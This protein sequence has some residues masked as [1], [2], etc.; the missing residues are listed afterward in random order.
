MFA[1]EL[2]LI[3][4][5]IEGKEHIGGVAPFQSKLM[6]GGQQ[7]PQ[8]PIQPQYP[9]QQFAVPQS[10]LQ[11]GIMQ[12]GMMDSQRR[13]GFQDANSN[14]F[15][16]QAASGFQQFQ[17]Q[18]GS[19][20]VQEQTIYQNQGMP[21]P[22]QIVDHQS[23]F[24]NPRPPSQQMLTSQ[25]SAQQDPLMFNTYNPQTNPTMRTSQLGPGAGNLTIVGGTPS[26]INQAFGSRRMPIFKSG[27]PNL[28]W[29]S[30]LDG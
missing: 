20:I 29:F 30:I 9:P 21:T 24:F 14:I 2:R 10:N 22:S 19:I 6:M 17:P 3:V 27:C 5:Y 28:N 8:P 4:E 15:A 16:N 12:S 26:T 1:G 11:V 23:T 25:R 7:P 13:G 18:P